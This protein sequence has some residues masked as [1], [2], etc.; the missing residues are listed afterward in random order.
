MSYIRIPLHFIVVFIS[1]LGGCIPACSFITSNTFTIAQ[2][3]K[4][5]EDQHSLFAISPRNKLATSRTESTDPSL[6]AS[7]LLKDEKIISTSRSKERKILENTWVPLNHTLTDAD[8]EIF[9]LETNLLKQILEFETLLERTPDQLLVDQAKKISIEAHTTSTWD[10]KNIIDSTAKLDQIYEESA[11][12]SNSSREQSNQFKQTA[13]GLSDVWTARILLIIS[14][15]LYGTNFTVVK[16]LN[17]YI[18]TDVG[19]VLRFALAA[20]VTL[21]WLFKPSNEQK[22]VDDNFKGT[23][24]DILGKT[25]HHLLTMKSMKKLSDL[26]FLNTPVYA[27]LEV[28][29][30]TAIG[31]LAQ[32]EGL[33]TTDAGKSAFICSL[34]VV[35]VPVLDFLAGKE[36]LF[37]QVIGA[38]MAVIGVAFLEIE[39]PISAITEGG[40]AFNLDTGDLLSLVQPIAFGLGFWRMEDAMR[41]FPEDAMKTTAAQ[42]FA[43]FAISL[44][45]C[46]ISSGFDGL[47]VISQ[48]LC[49]IKDPLIL[50]SLLWTGLVTTAF[51]VYLETLALKTLSAAE[52]TMIFSTEPLFGATFAGAVMGETFGPGGLI[53]GALILGAC[54]IS[55]I[56]FDSLKDEL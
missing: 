26:S 32:A 14:A 44:S 22:T 49:W 50:G 51:T 15:A 12:T 24:E 6:R 53:G 13:I 46:L 27:G 41:R 20:G 43:V 39:G 31:Y 30:W 29:M 1:W 42:L 47:P 54:V 25:F 2:L 33:E 52:T 37:R 16:I 23:G 7:V 45:Y 34:A 28:G 10:E 36:I 56:N 8:A 35:I 17:E 11:Y 55:N 38:L 40:G 3:R 48:I 21:P 18:P 19:A 9:D 5:V 4:P